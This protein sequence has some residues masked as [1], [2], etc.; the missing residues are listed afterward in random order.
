[1][2]GT[3]VPGT[4]LGGNLAPTRLRPPPPLP[5]PGTPRTVACPG[6][7]GPQAT[8]GRGAR[9][10]RSRRWPRP[11]ARVQAGSTPPSRQRCAP[12]GCGA[13][14]R[15]GSVGL[16][17]AMH[18]DA[19]SGQGGPPASRRRTRSPRART[20]RGAARSPG[21][22]GPGPPAGRRSPAWPGG[23]SL[24]ARRAPA[25][26]RA[27]GCAGVSACRAATTAARPASRGGRCRHRRCRER[28]C[29]VLSG[30]SAAAGALRLHTVPL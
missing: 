4:T 15:S 1:M 26:E 23:G 30:R 24:R 11:V 7:G 16:P 27:Y 22:A 13:A 6:A 28:R 29:R 2:W 25:P 8:P 20:P 19:A 12:A 3:Q 14:R 10:R 18:D 5:G 17:A 9:E 21:R